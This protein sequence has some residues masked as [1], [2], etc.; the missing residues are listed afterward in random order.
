MQVNKLDI[1]IF[2]IQNKPLG[3]KMKSLQNYEQKIHQEN[4]SILNMQ[5]F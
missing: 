1:D 4:E 5:T 3:S 2:T